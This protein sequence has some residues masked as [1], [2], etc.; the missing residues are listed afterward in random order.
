M[1]IVGSQ[2]LIEYNSI[3]ISPE[4][5]ALLAYLPVSSRTFFFAKLSNLLLYVLTFTVVIALPSVVTIWIMRG[6]LPALA[7]ACAAFLS[8]FSSALLVVLLYAVV[9]DR[10]ASRNLQGLLSGLQ[11]VLG[12]AVYGVFFTL[13]YLLDGD[14]FDMLGSARWPYFL[15]PGWFSSYVHLIRGNAD[16]LTWFLSALTVIWTGA[17]TCLAAGKLSLSYSE[18]LGTLATRTQTVSGHRVGS[19]SAHVIRATGPF[20]SRVVRQLIVSQFRNDSKF[21]MSVL[22]ILPLTFFYFLVGT[23]EGPL[24][25]P[26]V[27]SDLEMGRSVLLYMLIFL[28]PMM[29]RTHVTHSDSYRASWVFY[30]SPI[31]LV[32]ILIAEKNVLMRYFVLPFLGVLAA[33]LLFQFEQP[34]HVLLHL[35]VLG[36][37][38]HL[39][40]QLAF[41]LAPDLP[42]SHPNI[43][44]QQS[45][46]LISGVLVVLLILY[47]GFPLMFEYFYPQ[48]RI[49]ALFVAGLGI[50]NLVAERVLRKRI[51]RFLREVEFSE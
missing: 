34:Y 26:F 6:F 38:A 25:D 37:L 51:P 44:G 11:V 5:H 33:I 15:P 2:I 12:I 28:F 41:M 9:L 39:F 35:L 8:S 27:S 31:D 43:K 30:T 36:L 46:L 13:S 23:R 14:I 24:V 47:V 22:A 1:F 3:I 4:D 49:F 16:G 17:L 50:L 20:E 45:R 21:K 10:A 48:M 19:G 32:E 7:T 40:L 18:K 42:F 29:L